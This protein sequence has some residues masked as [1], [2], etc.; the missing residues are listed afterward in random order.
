MSAFLL[1]FYLPLGGNSVLHLVFS[2]NV[3]VGLAAAARW[4]VH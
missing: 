4:E 1:S 3:N 2:S